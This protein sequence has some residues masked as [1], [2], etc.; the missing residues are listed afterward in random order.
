VCATASLELGGTS[1]DSV[2]DPVLDRILQT[3]LL[4]R[5][6]C[7]VAAG[8]CEPGAVAREEDLGGYIPAARMGYPR[9]SGFVAYLLAGAV[10][11]VRV[12]RSGN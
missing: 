11:M 12:H 2:R 9:T 6:F 10:L 5:A 8:H 3:G 7:T 4:H 1:P